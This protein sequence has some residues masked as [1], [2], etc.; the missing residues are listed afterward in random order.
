[1]AA[2]KG[3]GGKQAVC[4]RYGRDTEKYLL[5]LDIKLKDQDHIMCNRTTIY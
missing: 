2:A 1:M 5:T 4:T 3:N